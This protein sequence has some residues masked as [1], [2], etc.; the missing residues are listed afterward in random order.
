MPLI[1]TFGAGGRG[2]DRGGGGGGGGYRTNS[3]LDTNPTVGDALEVEA[4]TYAVVVGGG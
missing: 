4:G 3:P 2:P 1:G